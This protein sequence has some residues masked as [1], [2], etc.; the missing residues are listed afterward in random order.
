[1]G[2][3]FVILSE[4]KMNFYLLYRENFYTFTAVINMGDFAPR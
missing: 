1:M 4:I 3:D 2:G